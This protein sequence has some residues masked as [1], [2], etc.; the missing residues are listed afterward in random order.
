MKTQVLRSKNWIIEQVSYESGWTG[1][2]VYRIYAVVGN[3][4]TDR[5]IQD[6]LRR[7]LAGYFNVSAVSTL[8]QPYT[9]GQPLT[10]GE[11]NYGVAPPPRSRRRLPWSAV[12]SSSCC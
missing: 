12:L 11:P 10:G 4:Y 8:S 7:D 9:P 2:D 5:Q 3:Q 6:Q 1:P